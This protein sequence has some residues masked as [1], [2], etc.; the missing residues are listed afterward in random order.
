[1]GSKVKAKC[2]FPH[3][4]R[5]IENGE[6][7]IEVNWRSEEETRL[8]Q[9]PPPPPPPLRQPVTRLKVMRLKFIIEVHKEICRTEKT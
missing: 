4:P 9:P 8:H 3:S 7:L 1:M 5:D 6:F 2:H